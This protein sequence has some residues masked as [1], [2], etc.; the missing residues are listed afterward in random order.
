MQRRDMRLNQLR[1]SVGIARYDV[2][3]VAVANAIVRRRWTLAV[4]PRGAARVSPAAGPRR[5]ASVSCITR[6]GPERANET[7]AA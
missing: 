6:R 1:D 5:R 7:L 3:P 4:A 2:D